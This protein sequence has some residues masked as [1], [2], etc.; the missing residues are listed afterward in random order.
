MKKALAVILALALLLATGCQ[1]HESEEKTCPTV[2]IPGI[3]GSAFIDSYGNSVW[4]PNTDDTSML[5]LL[6]LA[7]NLLKMKL[8]DA[9]E[10]DGAFTPVCLSMSDYQEG[11]NVGSQDTYRALAVAL[12]EK[13]GY[14]NVFFFGYDWRLDNLENADKLAAYIDTV[15]EKTGA[16]KVNIVAHSMGGLLTSGYLSKYKA[17][18]KI[19]QV[20]TCG[21]PFSGAQNAVNTLRGGAEVFD[22]Y[23]MGDFASALLPVS[24]S[25]PSLY[26]LMPLSGWQ[27]LSLVENGA[28]VSEATAAQT[29]AYAFAQ[30]ITANI[31]SVWENVNHTNLVGTLTEVE[32][33]EGVVQGDGVVSTRSATADGAFEADTSYFEVSHTALVTE[34]A[35]IEKI[36]TTL[37]Q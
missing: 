30:S 37:Y 25:M 12:S 21:T 16:K 18:G 33:D 20:V 19:N 17:E 34:Q 11:T 2:I 27:T 10:S 29:K 26:E 1:K 35:P 14:E 13:I 6:S 8:N 7:G 9:A 22:P 28:L 5:G 36:V 31:A 32:T 23:G 24:A 15:L 4:P 3:L